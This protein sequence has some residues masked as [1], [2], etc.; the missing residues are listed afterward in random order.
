MIC[1]IMII[2]RVRVMKV[3]FLDDIDLDYNIGERSNHEF[4]IL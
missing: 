4:N 1:L 3:V 2:D